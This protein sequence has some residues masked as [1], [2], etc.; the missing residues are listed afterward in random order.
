MRHADGGPVTATAPGPAVLTGTVIGV[1]V[2]LCVHLD[3]TP[4]AGN[5]TG[6]DQLVGLVGGGTLLGVCLLVWAI[7]TLYL[8]GRER[9][10]S[11]KVAA[12]PLVVLAALAIGVFFRPG[13]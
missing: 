9:R 1:A 5:L 7:K 12:A 3:R 8:V 2:L 13:G 11:W 6:P 10:W 4:F